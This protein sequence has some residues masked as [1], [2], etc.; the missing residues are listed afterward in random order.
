MNNYADL[1]SVDFASDFEDYLE[2]EF[3]WMTLEQRAEYGGKA[4][5]FINSKQ[6]E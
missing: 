2:K 4:M 1:D 6:A 3:P 5:D